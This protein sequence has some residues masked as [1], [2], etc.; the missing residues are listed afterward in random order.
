MNQLLVNLGFW[1]TL[2]NRSGYAIGASHAALWGAV[3][4]LAPRLC[5][6][7]DRN[8]RR[9][10]LMPLL[11]SPA[12]SLTAG[13]RRFWYL[14]F[15]TALEL[16]TSNL[17]EP[18]Y[19]AR[20]LEYLRWLSCWLWTSARLR[21]WGPYRTDTITPPCLTRAWCPGATRSAPVRSFTS[22]LGINRCWRPSAHLYTQRLL[23]MDDQAHEIGGG[24]NF[25]ASIPWPSCTTAS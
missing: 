25:G 5:R 3:A 22:F 13:A 14:R 20:T 21:L 10:E 1:R 6:T 17:L 9:G 11:L 19:M 16:I 15:F 18:G 2:W 7:P 24:T 8:G 4:A 23:A 12:R